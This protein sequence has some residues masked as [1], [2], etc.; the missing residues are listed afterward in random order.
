MFHTNKHSCT[1]HT[2]YNRSIRIDPINNAHNHLF[3]TYENITNV[4]KSRVKQ[5][6]N[7]LYFVNYGFR[8]YFFEVQSQNTTQAQQIIADHTQNPIA[9]GHMLA[10]A[11]TTRPYYAKYANKFWLASLKHSEKGRPLQARSAVQFHWTNVT[12]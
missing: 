8:L 10:L 5:T 9:F 6:V 4:A 12:I 2:E 3:H 1:Q 11:F 7:G